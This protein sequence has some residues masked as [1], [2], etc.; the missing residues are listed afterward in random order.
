MS[1]TAA[2][3]TTIAHIRRL[4]NDERGATA[5]EYAMLASGIAVTIAATVF[6]FGSQLKTTFY[7]KIAALL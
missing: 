5:I 2:L 6:S 3:R 7:D 1:S 4:V